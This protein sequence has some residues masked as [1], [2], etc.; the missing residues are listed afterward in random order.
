LGFLSVPKVVVLLLLLLLPAVGE[1]PAPVTHAKNVLV[2]VAFRLARRRRGFKANASKADARPSSDTTRSRPTRQRSHVTLPGASYLNAR[3]SPLP[4][5]NVSMAAPSTSKTT[6]KPPTC[7]QLG[8]KAE[9]GGM[10]MLLLL[11]AAAVLGSWCCC[12]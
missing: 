4:T 12:C 3:P 2:I 1:M 5:Q 9:G 7:N 11:P 6:T 10:E 8:G